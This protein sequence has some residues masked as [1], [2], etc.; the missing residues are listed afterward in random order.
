MRCVRMDF[1]R[2]MPKANALCAKIYSRRLIVAND[3]HTL[4]GHCG[5]LSGD[6]GACAVG[7]WNRELAVF[8][9]RNNVSETHFCAV[10]MCVVHASPGRSTRW[11][12]LMFSGT[13]VLIGCAHA[14]NEL[15][16]ETAH[17]FRLHDYCVC[18]IWM[19]CARVCRECWLF[20]LRLLKALYHAERM[21]VCQRCRSV[22][23]HHHH[24]GN[25]N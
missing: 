19:L 6:R 4:I 9:H 14:W 23:R 21:R 18:V 13:W 22:D 8:G 2:G 17:H 1:V 7:A 11:Q 20:F 25:I 3:T 24:T 12:S 15:T 10:C 16:I 5:Y